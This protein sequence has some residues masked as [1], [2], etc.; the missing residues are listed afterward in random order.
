MSPKCP[1]EVKYEKL[2]PSRNLSSQVYNI[3][4][5]NTVYTVKN[6]LFGW[7]FNSYQ[8]VFDINIKNI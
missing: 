7:G 4:I 2:L 5:L 3:A 8:R 6:K 1:D